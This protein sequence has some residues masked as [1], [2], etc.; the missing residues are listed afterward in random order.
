MLRQ[1]MMR[2]IGEKWVIAD[3]EV[4]GCRMNMGEMTAIH[5]GHAV[6][7]LYHKGF[8]TFNINKYKLIYYYSHNM[9]IYMHIVLTNI[10]L[11]LSCSLII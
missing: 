11:F 8:S 4:T 10:S 1:G 5:H 3:E 9:Y 7:Q 6:P 2:V